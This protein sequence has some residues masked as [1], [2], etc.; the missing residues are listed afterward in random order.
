MRYPQKQR[1]LALGGWL[2]LVLAFGGIMSVGAKLA[3]LY[4]D[5]N[6]MS[7]VLDGMAEEDGLGNKRTHELV[8]LLEKRFKVNNVRDFK[9]KDHIEIKRTPNGTELVMVYEIRQPLIYNVDLVTS[10][11]KKVELRK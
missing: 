4:M 7:G 11:A 10:F 2:L 3:P 5:H 9:V 8:S 6:T 1:G